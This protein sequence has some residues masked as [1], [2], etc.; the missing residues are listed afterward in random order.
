MAC[1]GVI[2]SFR[3]FSAVY[4]EMIISGRWSPHESVRSFAMA[5]SSHLD[6]LYICKRLLCANQELVTNLQ[7][8][9]YYPHMEA[10]KS[11]RLLAA[12]R[13]C[14]FST[15]FCDSRLNYSSFLAVHW[16]YDIWAIFSLLSKPTANPYYFIVAAGCLAVWLR[17][18][19][20]SYLF[21]ICRRFLIFSL[22][23]TSR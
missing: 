23:S 21:W 1:I 3:L 14:C 18:Q 7:P 6:D 12:G 8:P 17:N 11:L 15:W 4:I 5:S 13:V 19:P 20:E 16:L 22:H 10:L 9:P 2:L